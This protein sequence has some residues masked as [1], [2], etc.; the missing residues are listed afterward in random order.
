MRLPRRAAAGAALA[1]LLMACSNAPTPVPMPGPVT[2]KGS[3]NETAKGTAVSETID[4]GDDYFSP[5]FLRAAPG[6]TLTLTLV[7]VGD[8][9]HTFTIDSLHI[10]LVFDKKGETRTLTLTVPPSATAKRPLVFYCKY[11]DEN[12]MQGAFYS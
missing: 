9:T 1:A 8:V 4:V 7:D 10:D 3:V 12:G 6:T 5:T 2:N 11:H